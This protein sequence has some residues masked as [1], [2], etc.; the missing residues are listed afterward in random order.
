MQEKT[1]ASVRTKAVTLGLPFSVNQ[2]KAVSD[3]TQ[4][5]GWQ[6][7]FSSLY[8]GMHGDCAR[9][10]EDKTLRVHPE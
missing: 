6:H 1:N 9:H 10:S 5:M 3:L 4:D 8:R 7:C 2:M